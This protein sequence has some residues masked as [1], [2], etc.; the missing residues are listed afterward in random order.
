MLKMGQAQDAKRE[1][2]RTIALHPQHAG[3]HFQL[4]RVYAKLG[5]PANAKKFAA[6]AAELNRQQAKASLEP[7]EQVLLR[8]QPGSRGADRSTTKQSG[9]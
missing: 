9:P 5:D 2:E 7:P 3:A 1:L 8:F 4:S 6:R